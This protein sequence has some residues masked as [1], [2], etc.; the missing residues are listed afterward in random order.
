MQRDEFLPLR[1]IRQELA[2][3][4]FT[5][6]RGGESSGIARRAMSVDGAVGAISPEAS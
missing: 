5:K 3:G 6:P 4:D 2:T 1:V